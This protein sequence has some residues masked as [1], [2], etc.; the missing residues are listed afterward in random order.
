MIEISFARYSSETAF[1]ARMARDAGCPVIAMTDSYAAPVAKGAAKVIISNSRNMGF[2]DSYVSF[3]SNMEKI[4]VL[5][6]KRN[7]KGNEERLMKM[8]SYLRMTG[9]Y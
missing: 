2:F 4:L 1:A 9:Q 5:V 7:R 8:E 3:F 6:S